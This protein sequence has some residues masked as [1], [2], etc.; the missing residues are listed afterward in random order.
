[1]AKQKPSGSRAFF[2]ELVL[3]LVVFVLCATVCLQVFASAKTT[4]DL[5]AATSRLGVEAQTLAENFKATGGDMDAL[6]GRFPASEVAGQTLSLYYDGDFVPVGSRDD[7]MYL[8]SCEASDDGALHQ[9][10]ISAQRIDDPTEADILFDFVVARYVPT[11]AS[12]PES[13]G[14][15]GGA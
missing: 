3:D 5:S 7:A 9:A 8:L 1:M 6:A 15:E 14:N 10:Q 11:I 13:L 2:L 4:S 12:A